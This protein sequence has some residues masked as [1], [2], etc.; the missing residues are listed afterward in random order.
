MNESKYIGKSISFKDCFDE[1]WK[2]GFYCG[3]YEG[4]DS[5]TTAVGE[6]FLSNHNADEDELHHYNLFSISVFVRNGLIVKVLRIGHWHE[7]DS[8]S[9]DLLES[10]SEALENEAESYLEK[11]T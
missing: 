2:E 9:D 7:C 6:I 1:Y 3:D 8:G 10:F 4:L 5:N 11:L